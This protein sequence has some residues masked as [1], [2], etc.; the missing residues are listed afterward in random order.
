MAAAWLP[1][2][3]FPSYDPSPLVTQGNLIVVTIN[4]RLGYLG[5]FAH[6]ATDAELHLDANYGLMDQQ[7]ALQWVK[8]NI[9]AFG[10]DPNRVTIF[11]ESA[12][13]QSVY[14]NLASP[15][16]EGLF[17]R[18]I[19]ESGAYIQFQDYYNSIVPVAIGETSGTTFGSI[20]NR[21]SIQCRM[22]ESNV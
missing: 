15:T 7:F 12:G 13:G 16:A 3:L 4:Y 1:G 11:G 8:R 19:A 18:A 17:Q 14:S 21:D 2:G 22:R 5:F 6:P 9:T 20:G 10:G